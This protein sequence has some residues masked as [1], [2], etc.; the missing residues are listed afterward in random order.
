MILEHSILFSI[1][2]FNYIHENRKEAFNLDLPSSSKKIFKKCK[3]KNE[4]F[5]AIEIWQKYNGNVRTYFH[6][7]CNFNILFASDVYLHFM[8]NR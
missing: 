7:K 6:I 3:K 8:F 5:N 1:Y 4:L 2:T